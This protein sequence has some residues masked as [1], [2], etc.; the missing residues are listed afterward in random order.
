MFSAYYPHVP[1][2]RLRGRMTTLQLHTVWRAPPRHIQNVRLP[3]LY[4]TFDVPVRHEYD[5]CIK[6]NLAVLLRPTHILEAW[7][8]ISKLTGS[9]THTVM[10]G[11][12]MTDRDTIGA[13]SMVRLRGL[14]RSTPL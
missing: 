3:L 13:W 8:S 12:Q 1:S 9:R 5:A 4:S 6:Q 10:C 14:D 7:N 11:W 2:H